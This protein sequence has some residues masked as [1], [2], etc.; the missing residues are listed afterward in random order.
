MATRYP[1]QAL[2]QTASIV[3]AVIRGL[4]SG[5]RQYWNPTLNTGAGGWE[6]YNSAHW[7]QYAIAMTEDAGSGY[8]AATYPAGISGVLTTEGY[9]VRGGG[10]PALGDSPAVSLVQS[11]GQNLAAVAGDATVPDTLQKALF[12]EQLGAATGTPTASVIST[13]LT[14]AQINAFAGRSIVFTSGAAFQCAARIVAYNP[15][16]GVLTL[17]APLAATPAAADTFII[18]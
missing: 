11:Q 16:G 6:A 17:A 14:N 3:Y 9:Y 10:S 12:C 15:T 5:T 7:S 4:V 18:I 8:Y 1:I 13:N 2:Y